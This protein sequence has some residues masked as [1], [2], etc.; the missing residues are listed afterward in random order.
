MKLSE[1]YE[2]NKFRKYAQVEE[3]ANDIT[4]KARV[5]YLLDKNKK[6]AIIIFSIILIIILITFH[7]NIQALGLVLLML[8]MLSILT[9]YFNTSTIICKNN[10]MTIKMNMQEI[11]IEYSKLKNVYLENKKSRIYLKKRNSFW[12]IILYET[13]NRNISSIYI[14][15]IF[16]NTS[17]VEKFLNTFK[18]K[19]EKSNN[20]IVKA[21][22]YQLKRLLIKTGIF[23]LVWAVILLTILFH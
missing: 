22:K 17:D 7:S 9:I 15:T 14:P 3:I 21:Q 2:K 6:L 1:I 16:L 23:I 10:K 8:T 19:T 5:K 18:V 20:N 13:P 4:L 11:Q 12:L